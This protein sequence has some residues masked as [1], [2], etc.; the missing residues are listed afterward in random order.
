VLFDLDGTLV[1]TAP[2][3]AQALN[4]LLAS[5]DLETLPYPVI[6]PH[7]SGGLR[8]LLRLATQETGV[9]FAD[10][11]WNCSFLEHYAVT[12]THGI[13]FFPGIVELLAQ[14]HAWSVPWAIVTNKP[15]HLAEK[16]MDFLLPTLDGRAVPPCCLVGGGSTFKPKPDPAGILHALGCCHTLPQQAVMVGDDA[17]DIAAGHAADV[18]TLAATYG[19]ISPHEQPAS[20][21][22]HALCAS[23]LAILDHLAALRPQ[24]PS[25][26]TARA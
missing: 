6:R 26:Q 21:G 22:A 9:S 19:Y 3:M 14:L 20:W 10:P 8:A 25:W 24:P 7:V 11:T 5:R 12:M 16:V 4:R 2:G 1:D 17:R 13:G 18:H 15:Q 23:P